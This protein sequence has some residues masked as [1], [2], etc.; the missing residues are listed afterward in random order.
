[1][2]LPSGLGGSARQSLPRKQVAPEMRLELFRSRLSL[3]SPSTQ[4]PPVA[5]KETFPISAKLCVAP[6]IVIA[7]HAIEAVTLFFAGFPALLLG[8]ELFLLDSNRR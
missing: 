7:G 3:E 8:D 5:A 4:A 6:V 2:F 1:M